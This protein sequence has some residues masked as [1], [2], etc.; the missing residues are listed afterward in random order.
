MMIVIHVYKNIGLLSMK[1]Y[2]FKMACGCVIFYC[3]LPL[4]FYARSVYSGDGV[5]FFKFYPCVTYSSSNIL[6]KKSQII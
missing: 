3:I 1:M 4:D 2:L 5:N 6:G